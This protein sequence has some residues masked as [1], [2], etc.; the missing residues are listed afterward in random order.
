AIDQN[1]GGV[2]VFEDDLSAALEKSHLE[3]TEKSE[4]KQLAARA[5]A[6]I[7]GYA[8]WLRALPNENPRS[9]RL[10]KDLYPAKF[11]FEIQSAH[12]VDEIFNKAVS[13][14]EMLH[15]EM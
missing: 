15:Q 14:K 4:I 8:E 11:E 12:S 13:R 3:E 9:F 10:G 2:S 6:A 5:V 7:R 1:L